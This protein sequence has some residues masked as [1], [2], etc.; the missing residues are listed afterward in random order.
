M[1]GVNFETRILENILYV[2]GSSDVSVWLL[3]PIL[4]PVLYYRHSYR[5]LHLLREFFLIPNRISKSVDLRTRCFTSGLNQF[6][7][8]LFRTWRFISFKLY[9]SNSTSEELC[10]DTNSSAVCISVCLTSLTSCTS[11]SWEKKLFCLSR[12]CGTLQAYQ[13]SHL[14]LVTLLISIYACICL[15][16]FYLTVCFKLVFFFHIFP[17]LVPT[18]FTSYIF[19]LSSVVWLVLCN[20]CNLT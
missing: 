1:Y 19:Q 12:N 2:V 4:S 17:L 14:L 18:V 6:R 10:S 9:D 20:C 11:N 8:H 15:L 7:W 16:Y 13:Y 5:F 3:R